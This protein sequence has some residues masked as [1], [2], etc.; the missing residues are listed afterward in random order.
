LVHK[1]EKERKDRFRNI[2]TTAT[3]GLRVLAG[4][5]P[6]DLAGLISGSLLAG[7][8]TAMNFANQLRKVEALKQES[9]MSYLV[10]LDNIITKKS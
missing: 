10:E 6:T 4:K 2:L 1:L 9:G 3:K 8:D 7:A 5:P